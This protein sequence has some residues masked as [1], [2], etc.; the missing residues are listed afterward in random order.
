[1]PF[2]QRKALL[3]PKSRFGSFSDFLNLK[4]AIYNLKSLVPPSLP[5]LASL[6]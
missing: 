3:H 4:S 2:M 6:L 1:M 5:L